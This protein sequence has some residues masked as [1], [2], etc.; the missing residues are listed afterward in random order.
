[1]YIYVPKILIEFNNLD[2]L[3]TEIEL[4][5]N[6]FN[7]NEFDINKDISKLIETL[8]NIKDL[9]HYFKIFEEVYENKLLIAESSL[10][11]CPISNSPYFIDISKEIAFYK[12][13]N[14]FYQ[15]TISFPISILL[16]LIKEEIIKFSTFKKNNNSK[17]FILVFLK[18][19]KTLTKVPNNAELGNVENTEIKLKNSVSSESMGR[20]LLSKLNFGSKL[21]ISKLFSS[22][23]SSKSKSSNE[24]KSTLIEKEE[25]NISIYFSLKIQLHLFYLYCIDFYSKKKKMNDLFHVLY[26]LPI[27]PNLRMNF[28][29]KCLEVDYD[30]SPLFSFLSIDSN[31]YPAKNIFFSQIEWD[32]PRCHQYHPIINSYYGKTKLYELLI[33]LL[34]FDKRIN[35]IQGMDSMATIVLTAI[36]FKEDIACLI[37][38]KIIDKT[39]KNFILSDDEKNYVKE[40]LLVLQWILTFTEPILSKHLADIGFSPE[41]YAVSWILNLFSSL[42]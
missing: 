34:N 40:Y 20:N 29:K 31:I 5:N 7:N 16:G 25:E 2:N 12:K 41:L 27:S 35:Y 22:K 39:M 37:L 26:N 21:N 30:T 14:I 9:V 33:A 4:K 17:D 24:D 32:I 19:F 28:W 8:F 42:I 10:A 11:P 1:M 36:D 6:F 23:S 18:N 3:K 38:Y 15:K 13:E